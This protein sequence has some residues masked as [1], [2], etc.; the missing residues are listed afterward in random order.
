MRVLSLDLEL[1]PLPTNFAR[2]EEAIAR[3]CHDIYPDAQLLRWAVTGI[4]APSTA[5]VEVVFTQL[6]SSSS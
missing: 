6:A 1:S 5:R 3:S 4:D 2:W